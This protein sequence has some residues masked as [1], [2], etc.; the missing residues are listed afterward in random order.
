MDGAWRRPREKKIAGVASLDLPLNRQLSV[1]KKK[2]LVRA[3]SPDA[4]TRL[5]IDTHLNSSVKYH[6]LNCD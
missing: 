6:N 1:E 5:L 2:T 4:K 3:E